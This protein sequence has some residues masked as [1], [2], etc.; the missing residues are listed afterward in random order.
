M[1]VA[2]HGRAA[3]ALTGASLMLPMRSFAG[4]SY[5]QRPSVPNS[6]VLAHSQKRRSS[7]SP[8]APLSST[9]K[10]VTL[11]TLQAMHARS[12]PIAMLTAHDF[13]S[14]HVAN[15]AG[16]DMVLVGD[17]L[18]MVALGMDD[19]SEIMVEEMLLHCRSVARGAKAAFVVSRAMGGSRA[20]LTE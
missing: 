20:Q 2:M 15:Q 16:M 19:T 5:R 6:N 8:L 9:R 14:A 11:Q 1:S 12:E 17:S 7:H 18:A 10:L 3:R 4:A 13:P